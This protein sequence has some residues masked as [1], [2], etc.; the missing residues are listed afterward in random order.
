M[1]VQDYEL[2]LG[3]NYATLLGRMRPYVGFG[4]GVQFLNLR[5]VDDERNI[6]FDDKDTSVGGYL[7]VGLLL[8]VTHAAH[9]G[10]EIRHLEGSDVTFDGVHI[11]TSYDQVLLVFGTSFAPEVVRHY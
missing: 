4:M 5:G 7:K 11:G 9:V 3:L 1:K 2:S 10:F 8:Q 6:E